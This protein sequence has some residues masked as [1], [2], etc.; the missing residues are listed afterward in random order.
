MTQLVIQ[1]ARRRN[2]ASVRLSLHQFTNER[3]SRNGDSREATGN[4]QRGTGNGEPGTGSCPSSV[5]VV[6]GGAGAPQ[7]YGSVHLGQA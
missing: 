3:S 6:A 4:R 5:W 7:E 2:A 1:R